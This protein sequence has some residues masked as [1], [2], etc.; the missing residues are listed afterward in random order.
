MYMYSMLCSIFASRRSFESTILAF[1]GRGRETGVLV[2]G[3][4]FPQQQGKWF[5]SK[6]FLT[7]LDMIT[8]AIAMDQPNLLIVGDFKFYMDKHSDHDT[9]AFLDCLN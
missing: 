2:H 9:L 8:E 5:F 3:V 1:H 4:L 7:E 6:D